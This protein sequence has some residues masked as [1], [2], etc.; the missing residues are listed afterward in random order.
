MKNSENSGLKVW[1]SN[2]DALLVGSL[3]FC[4]IHLIRS[5][6]FALVTGLFILP[7]ESVD[8]VWISKFEFQTSK[9]QTFPATPGDLLE[10]SCST[11]SLSH[12]VTNCRTGETP[13]IIK[14]KRDLQG[15]SDIVFPRNFFRLLIALVAHRKTF[16]GFSYSSFQL[17]GSDLVVPIPK[18]NCNRLFLGAS[19]QSPGINAY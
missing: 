2:W 9:Y 16:W 3:F 15:S 5:G 17:K 13:E 7:L 11:E 19:S 6:Y 12:N 1:V 18:W 10:S 8:F 4:W 14:H